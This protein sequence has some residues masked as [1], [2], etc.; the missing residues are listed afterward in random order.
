MKN[1]P[2]LSLVHDRGQQVTVQY[3]IAG[4]LVKKG[5]VDDRPETFDNI[6][7][8]GQAYEP[9]VVMGVDKGMRDIGGALIPAC[10]DVHMRKV[11]VT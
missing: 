8:Y 11:V 1:P 4:V 7:F 9:Y 10:A 3:F 5:V 6:E 2:Y